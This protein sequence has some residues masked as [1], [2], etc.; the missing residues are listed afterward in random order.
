VSVFVIKL[1][2]HS[3]VRIQYYAR[4]SFRSISSTHNMKLRSVSN[5]QLLNIATCHVA[6]IHTVISTLETPGVCCC[7]CQYV[8]N[9]DTVLKLRHVSCSPDTHCDI[10]TRDTWYVLLCVSICLE[11]WY[12]VK[13]E[14]R[15][16]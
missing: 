11:L 10:D 2:D 8:L 7:V 5:I 4:L 14:T 9:C 13:I 16:V 15:I 1:K 6:P 12:C 3:A